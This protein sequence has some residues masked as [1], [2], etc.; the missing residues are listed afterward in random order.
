MTRF[1]LCGKA[2]SEWLGYGP[3]H[4]S[5]SLW[6]L[7]TFW[8][9]LLPFVNRAT[10]YLYITSID[11]P[12]SGCYMYY[13]THNVCLCI[14]L[15]TYTVIQC[16]RIITYLHLYL[17]FYRSIDLF[18]HPS[19]YLS[20]YLPIYLSTY[21]SIY[22]SISFFLPFLIFSYLILSIYLSVYISIYLLSVYLSIYLA[23]SFLSL[24]LSLSLP[25]S[26]CLPVCLS[27]FLSFFHLS[28]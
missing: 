26:L 8:A 19:T 25:L 28:I 15:Q 20:I 3:W 16:F 12:C 23:L 18:F 17:S 27:I 13:D 1:F 10:G 21:P 24:S 4:P 9:N 5:V 6:D 7:A 14:V 11:K 2:R 22:L